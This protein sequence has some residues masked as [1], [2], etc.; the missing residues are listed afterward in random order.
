MPPAPVALNRL[1]VKTG[2]IGKAWVG[3]A[4][5]TAKVSE[6]DPVEGREADQRLVELGRTEAFGREGVLDQAT[7]LDQSDQFPEAEAGQGD[8]DGR[9]VGTF[10]D[11]AD[12]PLGP[13]RQRPVPAPRS[14][15]RDQERG[16]KARS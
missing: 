8:N 4:D 1:E 13:E 14:Q 9:I 15:A 2:L 10:G 12:Q 6:T 11:I 7:D 16:P 5:V 3:R